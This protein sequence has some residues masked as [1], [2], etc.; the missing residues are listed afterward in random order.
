MYFYYFTFTFWMTVPDITCS[1][2]HQ[3]SYVILT[4]A[5]WLRLILFWFGTHCIVR[6]T[7]HFL[8]II[9]SMPFVFVLQ[10]MGVVQD[11]SDII[12]MFISRSFH[13][14]AFNIAD[15]LLFV[16]YPYHGKYILSL[17]YESHSRWFANHH[18]LTILFVD[19]LLFNGCSSF[20][21]H[22]S[23]A[24]FLFRLP[25]FGLCLMSISAH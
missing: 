12:L 7:F 17:L 19:K 11:S 6:Q 5:F 25:W 9:E 8:A 22:R 13:T 23:R 15:H 10:S 16:V 24:I 14:A 1:V 2:S 4:I 3:L 21:Y 20:D 18:L